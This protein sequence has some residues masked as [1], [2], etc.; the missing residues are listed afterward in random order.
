MRLFFFFFFASTPFFTPLL[1]SCELLW[2]SNSS[3]RDWRLQFVSYNW[4]FSIHSPVL[5][6]PPC[7]Q[8]PAPQQVGLLQMKMGTQNMRSFVAKSWRSSGTTEEERVV[9][10]CMLSTFRLSCLNSHCFWEDVSICRWE[11][12][13]CTSVYSPWV[14]EPVRACFDCGLARFFLLLLRPPHL[15]ANCLP[16]LP[17]HSSLLSYSHWKKCSMSNW[18]LLIAPETP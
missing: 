3:C 18:P 5:P 6:A 15:P 8:M 11:K 2:Q 9:V 1:G 12:R 13:V 17:F 7:L 4:A 16:S 14:M 10:P